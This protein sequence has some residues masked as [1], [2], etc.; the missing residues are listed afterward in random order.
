M[1]Q[2]KVYYH[3]HQLVKADIFIFNINT[4][5][6]IY[7]DAHPLYYNLMILFWVVE[8]VNTHVKYLKNVLY[9]TT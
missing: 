6:N 3:T 8:N 7:L 9:S 1:A 4:D 2:D 5:V